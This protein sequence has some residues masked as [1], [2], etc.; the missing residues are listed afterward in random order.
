MCYEGARNFCGGER[1]TYAYA[2]DFVNILYKKS[3]VKAILKILND[4][5]MYPPRHD[6]FV[7]L[8]E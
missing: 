2:Y 3:Y 4:L 6:L 8:Y 1:T 7:F 5:D